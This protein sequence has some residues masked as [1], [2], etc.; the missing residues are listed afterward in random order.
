MALPVIQANA[1]HVLDLIIKNY[2]VQPILADP[3]D[4]RF[5]AQTGRKFFD[6]LEFTRAISLFLTGFVDQ[7]RAEAF[8]GSYHGGAV[9]QDLAIDPATG[10]WAGEVNGHFI[11]LQINGDGRLVFQG[12]QFFWQNFMIK[13]SRT[14]AAILGVNYDTLTQSHIQVTADQLGNNA[15]ENANHVIQAGANTRTTLAECEQSIFQT[16]ENRLKVSIEGH[17]PQNSSIEIREGIETTN[18]EICQG[19]FLNDV[20]VEMQWDEDGTRTYTQ[21][22]NN[23]Y[24]GQHSFINKNQKITHWNKLLTAENLRFF[25][26]FLLIHYRAFSETTGKWSI[27]SERMSIPASEYW[28]FTIRFVSDE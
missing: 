9:A 13:F 2:T 16:A 7:T 11:R 27:V 1:N 25:R 26:W 20:Y 5:I 18:R 10:V 8:V 4:A 15:F 24:S 28:S 21:F 23:I 22:T 17:L 19:Y 6:A 14:G 3:N 12:T